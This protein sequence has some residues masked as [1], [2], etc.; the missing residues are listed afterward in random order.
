VTANFIHDW[1]MNLFVPQ[2]RTMDES[3]AAENMSEFLLQVVADWNLRRNAELP[4]LV[5]GNTRNQI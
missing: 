4:A 2:T 1:K 3:Y 5:T